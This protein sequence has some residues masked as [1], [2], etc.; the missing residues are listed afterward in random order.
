[1]HGEEV[2]NRQ[3]RRLRLGPPRTET[4]PDGAR[5]WLSAEEMR[6]YSRRR[7]LPSVT[8]TGPRRL[9]AARVLIV[10]AAGLGSPVALYLAAAG[11]GQ[12]GLVAFDNVDITNLQR[13]LLHG[14][15]D[16][17]RPKLESAPHR[18]L[19]V[20]PNAYPDLHAT[21][22]TSENALEIMGD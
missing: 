4:L 15:A 5:P 22:L 11:V 21:R 17:G 8:I 19:D 14:T 10:G 13:Q 2:P 18:L 9:K 7:L 6:G 16:V 20:N 12:L 1:M 3:D